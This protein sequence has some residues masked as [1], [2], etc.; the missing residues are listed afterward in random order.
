[1]AVADSL[2]SETRNVQSDT[3]YMNGTIVPIQFCNLTFLRTARCCLLNV[4][5]SETQA[6]AHFGEM[7]ALMYTCIE[8][9]PFAFHTFI[10]A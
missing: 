6:Q 3:Q 10:H 9:M 2:P 8:L 1:M 5:A 4:C 7:M